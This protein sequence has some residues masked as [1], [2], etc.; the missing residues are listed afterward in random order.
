MLPSTSLDSPAHPT[1]TPLHTK[2]VSQMW[3]VAVLSCRGDPNAAR[4]C[5]CKEVLCLVPLGSG[6]DQIYLTFPR[7]CL[8]IYPSLLSFFGCS[9]CWKNS[10]L[11]EL[12]QTSSSASAHHTPIPYLVTFFW[13]F[14]FLPLRMMQKPSPTPISKLL[15]STPLLSLKDMRKKSVFLTPKQDHLQW[16][17]EKQHEQPIHLISLWFPVEQDQFAHAHEVFEI[18]SVPAAQ[19]RAG[20]HQE[21]SFSPPCPAPAAEKQ[22]PQHSSFNHSFVHSP[23][24]SNKKFNWRGGRKSTTSHSHQ[25][26]IWPLITPWYLYNQ[27]NIQLVWLI[28]LE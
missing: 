17:Q 16:V 20:S 15:S 26:Y 22:Q 23:Q 19:S 2:G 27:E 11:K 5:A 21:I 13:A 1:P 14:P 7:L 18:S 24:S 8:E 6:G 3:R 28:M 25:P 10:P 9:W 12:K 4:G